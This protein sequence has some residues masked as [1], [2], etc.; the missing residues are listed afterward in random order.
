MSV[1]AF[2]FPGQGAQKVGA[3]KDLFHSSPAARDVF[4]RANDVLG[5]DICKLCFEGPEE[6]LTLTE[7]A[8][9]ALL[10][11]SAAALAAA[12]ERG[13]EAGVALG[14][15]LGE[16]TALYYAG[17]FDLPT[18]LSLVRKRG[19]LMGEAARQSGGAMA[20]ILGL[21]DDAVRSIVEQVARGRA[22][23]AANFNAPGQVVV[24]GEAEAVAD[25]CRA[26]KEAGAKR[27]V[28]LNVSGAFHS[29][30]MNEAAEQMARVLDDA[31]IA[32]AR[33]PVIMNATAQPTQRA[34]DIRQALKRQII[35]SVRWR[36]SLEQLPGLGCD[37]AVELGSNRLLCGML[38]R[39]V[40]ELP[41][42]CIYDMRSL[43]E[44][45]GEL[46]ETPAGTAER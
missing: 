29:P 21:E 30:L 15:S 33:I 10:T 7:N 2:M 34:E 18:A 37:V 26:A 28:P 4:L 22:L 1:V 12:R 16:Y 39:T 35:S 40:P 31:P 24:S 14:H 42:Y 19:E 38:R 27:A 44:V 13:L 45:A 6:E 17:A 8:Q 41:C 3:G 46:G 5:F 43:E 23:V 20:A 25:A 32:D 9:P 36:E 11:V